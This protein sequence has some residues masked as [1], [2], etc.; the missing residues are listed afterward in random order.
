[1]RL[2]KRVDDGQPLRVVEWGGEMLV[3]QCEAEGDELGVDGGLRC[4]A[5]EVEADGGGQ[6]GA[7]GE[8][9]VREEQEREG[10]GE[11]GEAVREGDR[12]VREGE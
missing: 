6:E 7:E 2:G 3:G 8:M 12:K 4:G 9:Q 10:D 11:A 1:M 5:D